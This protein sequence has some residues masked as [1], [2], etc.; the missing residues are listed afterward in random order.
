MKISKSGVEKANINQVQKF[1]IADIVK[2]QVPFI[3]WLNPTT[4]QNKI[5]ALTS[6]SPLYFWFKVHSD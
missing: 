1:Q 2:C 6:L 3:K 5:T 4:N